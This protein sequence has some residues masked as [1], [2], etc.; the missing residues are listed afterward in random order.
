MNLQAP[1]GQP[2]P[3]APSRRCSP[4]PG[5]L[6]R[7]MQG[8]CGGAVL[9]CPALGLSLGPDLSALRSSPASSYVLGMES[10]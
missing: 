7:K 10:A 8:T 9:E 3:P 6:R 1:V 2:P 5:S 4:G